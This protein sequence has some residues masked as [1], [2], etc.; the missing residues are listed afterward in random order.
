MA[1]ITINHNDIEIIIKGE[2][3]HFWLFR[4]FGDSSLVLRDIVGLYF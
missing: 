4:A 1:E 2:A 3:E